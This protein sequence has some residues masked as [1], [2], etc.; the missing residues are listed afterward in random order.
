MALTHHILIAD[1]HSIIRRGL[2]FILDAHFTGCYVNEADTIKE[3]KNLL[4]S[5]AFSHLIFDM[6]M[7]DDNII[8]HLPEIRKLYPNIP[9]LIYTMSPEEIYGK[10]MLDKGATGFLSKQ[11]S[12][13]VVIEALDLF[14]SGKAYISRELKERMS[15]DDLKF[16]PES[17]IDSLS[18]RE[19]I[20]MNYIMKGTGVKEISLKLDLKPTTVA[21][22]KA[23]IFNKLGVSNVMDMR[24]VLEVYKYA[25]S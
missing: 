19:L 21:T 8:E 20:V 10:R 1:D 22:Y 18:D 25:N 4:D 14:L 13:A 3:V 12:E 17:P 9:I 24:N 16:T 7:L 15:R 23:R 6:Q 11:S 5:F 2:K